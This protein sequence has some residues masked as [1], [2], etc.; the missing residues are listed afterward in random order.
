V[1]ANACPD[2]ATFLQQGD[3]KEDRTVA[4]QTPVDGTT[5]FRFGLDLFTRRKCNSGDELAGM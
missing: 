1:R 5:F 3:N 2:G 4:V